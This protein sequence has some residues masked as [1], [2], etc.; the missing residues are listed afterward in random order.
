[1]LVIYKAPKHEDDSY[2]ARFN[3][4]FLHDEVIDEIAAKDPYLAL[5]IDKFTNLDSSRDGFEQFTYKPSLRNLYNLADMGGSIYTVTAEDENEGWMDLILEDI[6]Y[7]M[8][9]HPTRAVLRLVKSVQDYRYSSQHS[10]LDV[11]CLNLIYY[12]PKCVKMVFRASDVKEELLYD[13]ILVYKFFIKP[14]FNDLLVKLD[15]F[16]STTQNHTYFYET[17][18]KIEDLI[19]KSKELWEVK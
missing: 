11:P 1:M 18:H 8:I 7:L 3:S 4:F 10:G 9:H 16:A 6:K 15:L 19:I 2:Y 12:S 13:V 5:K 14:F 17:I